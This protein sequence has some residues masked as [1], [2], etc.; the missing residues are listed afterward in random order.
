MPLS[1]SPPPG[2]GRAGCAAPTRKG[3]LTTQEDEEGRRLGEL[4]RGDLAAFAARDPACTSP[5]HA[6]LFYQ[7]RGACADR[8]AGHSA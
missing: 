5:L 8:R 2:G 4:A 7:V 3:M 1:C 6:L